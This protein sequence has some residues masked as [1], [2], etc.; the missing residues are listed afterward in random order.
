[1]SRLLVGHLDM[2]SFEVKPI[3]FYYDTDKKQFL[4]PDGTECS[5]RDLYELAVWINSPWSQDTMKYG[6][7][8]NCKDGYT[9]IEKGVPVWKC[10]YTITGYEGVSATIIGYG[11]TEEDALKDCKDLFSKLQKEYNPEDDSV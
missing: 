5:K 4:Y 8:I 1:M 10:K 7:K 11:D 3:D 9:E 6:I 2:L